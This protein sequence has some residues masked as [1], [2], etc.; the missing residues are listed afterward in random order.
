M[1]LPPMSQETIELGL[2]N[3]TCEAAGCS[4]K[5]T[6]LLSVKVGPERT[7]QLSLCKDCVSKFKQPTT[8]RNR[9]IK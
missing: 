5:S 3:S 8:K 6:V 7:I 2:I 9:S 4:N 1:S